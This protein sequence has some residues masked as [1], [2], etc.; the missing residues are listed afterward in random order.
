MSG[1]AELEPLYAHEKVIKSI[2]SDD[3]A[4]EIPV[5]Q[6][7][8]AWERDQAQDLLTDLMEA[9]DDEDHASYFLGSI[10][11][12]KERTKPESAVIDGQQR[13]TTLT[14]LISVLRDLTETEETF[15][16][17]RN[18]VYQKGNP[19]EGTQSKYRLLTRKKDREFFRKYIQEG[20]ATLN[21]PPVKEL[22]GSRLRFI[23]NAAYF[24]GELTSLTAERR[25]KLMNFLLTK[26]Y[27]VSVEVPDE[28]AARRIFVVMNSRGLDLSP[29]DIL[30]AELLSR[31]DDDDEEEA[32]ADLWEG[33]EN[34]LGR[35]QFAE[36]F[37]HIRMI[38]ERDKPRMALERA[39]PI[40]VA[41]FRD[42]ADFVGNVLE[43]AAD[44]LKLITNVERAKK[45]FG[46]IAG[47]AVAALLK[48]DNKD[49]V[50]PVLH[51]LALTPGDDA[52][53][54]HFL[55]RF[56]RLVYQL[57]VTRAD[58]NA[59]LSRFVGVLN[60]IDP[61]GARE[62][63]ETTR[64]TRFASEHGLEL[65]DEEKTEFLEALD[66]DIYMKG[67]VVKPLLQRLDAL[68]ASSGATYDS[69]SVEHVLPQTVKPDSP[70]MK[71]FPDEAMRERW[72]HR[73]ANLVLLTQR[74]NTKASNWD[75]ERKKKEYF[76]G[77]DGRSPFPVTQ[78]VL[79]TDVWDVAALERLQTQYLMRLADHWELR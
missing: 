17:R 28:D 79:E 49:W 22:A 27:L 13:L 48:V 70:W 78:G 3:Y 24:H 59:R 54:A 77:E 12:V 29:T 34:E 15:L 4:F 56:E 7:P 42:D 74:I 6:R 60:E 38:H 37:G 58:I 44:R 25:N 51:K 63:R 26:C 52:E 71:L 36:L 19:D 30:K 47:Q 50:P 57:F 21:L 55:V 8:Y 64:R 14:I 2:F 66:G 43:P 67:R 40:V 45:R 18:Y 11:L 1:Q 65:T 46:E 39:F 31:I 35:E 68:L 75:F 32:V 62:R 72:T 53:V 61:H 10:V 9:M 41:A 5:Y 73:L 23:D 69:L 20:R 16:N 76:A 33:I